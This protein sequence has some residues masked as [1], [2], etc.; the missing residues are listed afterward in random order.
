MLKEYLFIFLTVIIFLFI[1]LTKSFGE[2]NVFTIN[3]VK[4]EGPIDINFSRYKYINIA[5]EDSFVI[6][7]K[8]ILLTR[9][10][11]KVSNYKSSE[12][13]KLIRNF[14]ILD[15][16]FK[17]NFY[18]ANIKITYRE[19]RIKKFLGK[20]NIS[21]SQPENISVV[22]FPV[23]F[24]KDEMQNF[25]ENFFYTK[26]NKTEIEN[27]LINFIL[28]LDDLEDISKI[29]NARDK[30][31]EI[32]VKSLVNKYNEKNYIFAMM[33]YNFDKLKI[34]LRI[35]FNNN[36]ISKN[37]SYKIKDIKNQEKLEEILKNLKLKII[38]LWK[39]ENLVNV[40]M[41]LSIKLKFQHSKLENLNKL[42]DALNIIKI[43][44]SY[45]LE[46]FNTNDSY[47]KIYYFGNP[48]KLRSELLHFGYQLK[49]NQG[50]WE[51]YLNE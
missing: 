42:R 11:E 47:F 13:K 28:P 33:D 49:N 3:N 5:F 41:P 39:E 30:L 37:F 1:S 27:E 16:S 20:K 36:K 15:E 18:K 26:W 34:H 38:D 23:L 31:E 51:L 21:F 2:E 35:N 40:S 46:E 17:S 22:F 24:I 32:E 12:I 50:L 25:N 4:V 43:I 44:D 8:K 29:T 48:K 9:D 19:D 7:M 10:L 14:H 6:L 45:N